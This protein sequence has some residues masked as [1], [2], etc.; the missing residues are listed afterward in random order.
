MKKNKTAPRSFRISEQ[1]V[2][3]IQ[4]AVEQ[5]VAEGSAGLGELPSSYGTDL[6]Y[7]IAR[8]PKSLFL[9]WDLDW[10]QAFATA[11]VS[12]RQ[13]HLRI[14]RADGSIETTTE[15]NPADSRCCADVSAP[16]TQYY[17]ELGC[18]DGDE[19]RFL[20]R[21]T[22]ATT[23]EAEMSADFSAAFATL[24]LH[25]SFQRLLETLEERTTEDAVAESE[26]K[27][28]RKGFR[29]W[30]ANRKVFLSAENWIEPERRGTSE[31]AM[32]LATAEDDN[33]RT[34]LTSELHEQWRRLGER[35]GGSSW[36]Y[37]SSSNFGPSTRA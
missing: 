21:S 19:W 24:P 33:A 9:Y 3:E 36:G 26:E 25:L 34:P 15:I 31:L 7:V 28:W 17:C 8:D 35:F 12:P 32:L 30:A 14:F 22:T 11:G 10:P 18:F 13:V 2:V 5:P 23:P 6:L 29:R 37:P 20:V 27:R 16:G 4:R 1:P